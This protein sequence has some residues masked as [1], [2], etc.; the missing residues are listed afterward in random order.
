MV[1][2]GRGDGSM[3]SRDQLNEREYRDD[4]VRR[5]RLLQPAQAEPARPATNV[6]QR[7]LSQDAV[8][9]GLR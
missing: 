1:R 2:N 7:G 5:I 3:A 4:D 6:V 8:C 9:R